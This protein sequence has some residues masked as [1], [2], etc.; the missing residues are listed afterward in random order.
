[1]TFFQKPM[2]MKLE[3]TQEK[4]AQPHGHEFPAV[5]MLMGARVTFV[6]KN[7]QLDSQNQTANLCKHTVTL[8]LRIDDALPNTIFSRPF[9]SEM[10]FPAQLMSYSDL[11]ASSPIQSTIKPFH[12][13]HRNPTVQKEA[14]RP[15]ESAPTTIPPR[16]YPPHPY[17]F[18]H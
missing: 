3:L 9:F 5:W 11:Q 15:I 7:F 16:P 2:R 10:H 13:N 6:Q 8:L 17:I 4:P 1:M 14:I 12:R 18:T